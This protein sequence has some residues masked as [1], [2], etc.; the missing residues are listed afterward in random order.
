MPLYGNELD[1]ETTPLRGRPGPRR[2]ARQARRLR[3]P[4][5]ARRERRGRAAQD[6]SSA[7]MLRGRGIARHGYPVYR[8]G[9]AE[10]VGVVTSGSHSP[11]LGHADRDGLRAARRGGPGTMVEVGI[12][13]ARGSRPR[14]SRCR[15]ID[16][17]ADEL[18]STDAAARWRWPAHRRA[19]SDPRGGRRPR[20]MCPTTCA[21]PRTTSGCAL[22]GGRGHRGHHALRRGRAGRHRL[23]GAA[24]GRAGALDA[25]RGVRGHRVGQDRQR[26]VRARW[27]ARSSRSTRRWPERPSWSTRP[28]R[29]GLDDP[30][31]RSTT[32]SRRRRPAGRRRLPRAHRRLR[33]RRVAYGP[34]TPADRERMLAALGIDSVDALFDD[35]P[36]S[37]RAT[38]LDLPAAEPELT[39]AARHG[40]LAARNRVGPGQLPGRRRLPPSHP[41]RPWTR[42]CRGAS[43]HRL[44]ALPAG[45]QPGHAADDLRVPVAA[46]RADRAA[47]RLRLALRRRGGDRR[48]GADDHPRRRAASGCWPAAPSTATTSTTTRTYFGRRPA[49]ARGAATLAD[50][51]TDLAA[52]EAALADAGRPGR[53]RAARPAQRVRA[54]WSRWPRRRALAHAAGALFVAVVEPVS[55]AV[56]APPGEYG[57][58]IAAGEGQPLGIAPQYGGPYLGIL[59]A[60][61]GAHPPDPRPAGR[62]D[63]RPRRPARL[64]HDAARA[65]AGH[66]AR[67]GGQQHLHQPGAVRAGGDRRT[68]R[69]SGRTGCATWR[70]AARPRAAAAGARPR[71]RRRAARPQRRLPQRVR[72][73]RARRAR[74]ST[75]RC[76][77]DGVLAGLPLARWYPDDPT[78]RDALLVCATEVT[79]DDDIERFAAALGRGAAHER[80][81]ERRRRRACSRARPART[82]D[83]ARAVGPA[84]QPTLAELSRARP[85]H[86]T[87]CRTRRPTRSPASRRTTAAPTPL[88]LPELNEPEV[89]RHFTQPVA[90]QL[91]RRRRAST[92]SAR[93]P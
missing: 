44:H 69:R 4:R 40:R 87:R 49:R 83:R 23:R 84:L 76:W 26:P 56:L 73:P 62:P 13:D 21:T 75:P 55:L 9:E 6:A 79:T 38:G 39:L 35:I 16:G 80:L 60:H 74:R 86:A 48:G 77:S 2:Q 45:D 58:D 89:I 70:P 32:P 22:D 57:A 42:S 30:P 78:L 27:R 29:R 90:P 88:G 19:T 51:T 11:T 53:G 28:V 18:A 64:R 52:L 85:R 34:H 33:A 68:S 5:R 24:G 50:G 54:C 36:A 81:A 31:A 43:S 12:R 72:G 65:R 3:G 8:P 37:V 14:S 91:L 10:A 92:R 67:Q 46:R 93:A 1:R 15:S 17:H 63:D 59:A 20:W 82:W 7:S 41:G 47:G 71:R 66:P 25:A 61:R